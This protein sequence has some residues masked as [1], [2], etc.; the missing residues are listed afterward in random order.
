MTGK[1]TAV[2]SKKLKTSE[3]RRLKMQPK[4]EGPIAS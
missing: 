4:P 2:Y 3:P 1:L